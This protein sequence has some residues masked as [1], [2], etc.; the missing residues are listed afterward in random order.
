LNWKRGKTSK[1]TAAGFKRI[2]GAVFLQAQNE[3]KI[4]GNPVKLAKSK[5]STEAKMEKRP[6]TLQETR[7]MH[8]KASPFWRYMIRAAFFTGLS[9]GDLIT[10][11]LRMVDRPEAVIRLYR[12]K[13]GNRINAPISPALLSMFNEIWPKRE[14]KYF[15]PEEAERYIKSGASSFSQEF[16]EIMYSVGLVPARDTKKKRKGSGR[17]STRNMTGLGFHNF[18]HTFVTL[19]KVSGAVDSIAKEL[20]GHRSSAVNANYTHLPLEK[21]KE[22]VEKLPEF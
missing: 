14:Q 6:F 22:A 18:R 9:M 3:G 15:W 17:A 13:T 16:Y 2:L 12:R 11:E 5:G 4:R 19:I 8:S 1:S 20:V 21:L 10:L 7:D